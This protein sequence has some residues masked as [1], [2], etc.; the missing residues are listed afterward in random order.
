[1]ATVTGARKRAHAKAEYDAFLVG[2]PS[3]KLLDRLS[4]KWVTL[5]LAALG[6]VK[7]RLA[8][9]PGNDGA[10]CSDGLT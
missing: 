1:M 10:G 7:Q 9:R 6:L 3:R 5:V 8:S 4:D 2:C